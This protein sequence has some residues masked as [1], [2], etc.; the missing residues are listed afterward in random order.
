MSEVNSSNAV[1][2]TE[3]KPGNHLA[4][5]L[6]ANRQRLPKYKRLFF[7]YGSALVCMNSVACG[8]GANTF[9]RRSLKI[10]SGTFLRALPAV[11]IPTVFV[12]IYHEMLITHP[13][14]QGTLTCPVCAVMRSAYVGVLMGG[15][16][17]AFLA[18]YIHLTVA[19]HIRH[20]PPKGGI[21]SQILAFV[22]PGLNRIK[23]LL[24]LQ[25]VTSM[26][27]ASGQVAIVEDLLQ[28]PPAPETQEQLL[29]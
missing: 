16:A 24:L 11:V 13:L 27:V 26:V 25:A 29:K 2:T 1:E 9:F 18:G 3:E 8:I 28:M 23:Y 10:R 6:A 17:P 7:D 12:G 21:F 14:I 15:L 19:P 20:D 4:L 5:L 22:K